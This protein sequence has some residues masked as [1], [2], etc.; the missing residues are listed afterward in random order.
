MNPTVRAAIP[1]D[2]DTIAANNVA[3]ALE[4]EH[5]LL[6]AGIARAGA[7]AVFA[8]AGHG[9]YFVAEFDGRIVGQLMITYEWSDWRNGVFWWIQ[10][11]YVAPAARRQGVFRALYAHVEALAKG[12]PGVCGMRLYVDRDNRRA[13][14]TYRRCGMH[15]GGYLVMEVD[16][17][18]AVQSA[19]G[20]DD[21]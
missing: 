14:E 3:M 16:Y 15:D 7:R 18:G 4:A 1:A 8:G 12:D 2:A 17:S 19:G 5:K 21:A 20:N 9:R 13:Q 11:V 10:S 6:D